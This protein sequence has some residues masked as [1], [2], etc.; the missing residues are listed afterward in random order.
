MIKIEKDYFKIPKF[1][2]RRKE[3]RKKNKNYYVDKPRKI[4]FNFNKT[5][6]KKEV[7]PDIHPSLLKLKDEHPIHPDRVIECIKY[8]KSMESNCRRNLNKKMR[9]KRID[10]D[11]KRLETKLSNEILNC[12]FY[13]KECKHY[14]RTGDWISNFYGENQEH[15]TLWRSQIRNTKK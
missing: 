7:I 11:N 13:V 15:K 3:K 4:K 8:N 5:V 6:K 14:L 12:S 1:L 9:S 10:K 2:D